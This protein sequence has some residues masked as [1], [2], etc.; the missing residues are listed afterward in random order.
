LQIAITWWSRW[1]DFRPFTFTWETTADNQTL[2]LPLVNGEAYDFDI[3]WGDGFQAVSGT[4][5]TNLTHA[6]A[7]AGTY[8]VQIW[9]QF[10]SISFNNGGSVG[11]LRSIDQWGEVVWRNLQYAFFGAT[12]LEVLA[13]DVPDLHLVNN[14]RAAFANTA[15]S[16]GNFN[17]W[18]TSEVTDM[19]YLFSGA[20]QF[21]QPLSSWKVQNV[22]TMQGMFQ[23]ASSFDQD[24]SAWKPVKVATK[25][26]FSN[27]LFNTALSVYHYNALLGAWAQQEVQQGLTFTASPSWYGGCEVGNAQLG[28]DGHN[29]LTTTVANGGKSWT[30]TDGGLDACEDPFT[31]TRLVEAGD[32]TVELPTSGAGYNARVF[33]GDGQEEIIS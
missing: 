19:S 30:I 23:N 27:F 25:N 1:G 31:T 8:Q 9:G 16:G 18:D 24:L 2:T 29:F 5:L 33:W 4:S 10:P 7:T 17:A 21:N 14:L 28:I 15:I 3:E 13:N 22:T 26:G 12:E 6:Y 20:T 32:L 11:A